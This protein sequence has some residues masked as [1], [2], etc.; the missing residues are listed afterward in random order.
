MRWVDL[1]DWLHELLYWSE[2]EETLSGPDEDYRGDIRN[3]VKGSR[4]G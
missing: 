4:N 1:L 3:V 2:L